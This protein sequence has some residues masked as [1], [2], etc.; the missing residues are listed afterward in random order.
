M[1]PEKKK[2]QHRA[3]QSGTKAD[4]KQAKKDRR[5]GK[6]NVKGQNPKAFGRS[7]KGITARIQQSR[8]AEIQ[9]RKL[10]APLIDRSY[11]AEEPPPIVVGVVVRLSLTPAQHPGMRAPHPGVRA[12]CLRAGPAARSGCGAARLIG[13]GMCVSRVHAAGCALR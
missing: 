10:H 1:P 12:C 6:T 3:R 4:K 5:A 7:S 13:S 11:A 9:E 8:K 2:K